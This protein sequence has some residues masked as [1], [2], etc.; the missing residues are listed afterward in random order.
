MFR[1]PFRGDYAITQDFGEIIPGVTYNGTPHTGIDYACPKGTPVLASEDGTVMTVGNAVTGYGN[2]V[3]ICHHDG[4]GT[5][6]A[7]LDTVLVKQWQTVKQGQ[8]I[9]TSGNS[10]YS[11]GPH[12]HFEY[13]R[14]ASD[15]NTVED[16]KTVLHSVFEPDTNNN[17]PTQEK[18][19]FD[20]VESGAV[21]VVCD[22]ANVRC[23]CDMNRIIGQKKRGDTLMVS[24]PVTVWND[25][26][27]RD[28]W[29]EEKGCW[30]RIAEHDPYDQI[31]RNVN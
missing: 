1:Q 15:I 10:G 14:K 22:V 2:F 28:F 26:P 17:T 11:T 27:Y 24:G 16:P 19:K 8:V 9:G 18:P 31:I 29:D 7:H 12:L 13:R 4:S 5:V 20:T 6:Y 30:L 21:V 25:I 23:H 3:I